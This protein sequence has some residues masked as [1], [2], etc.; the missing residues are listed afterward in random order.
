MKRK[1]NLFHIL[2]LSGVLILFNTGCEKQL[3]ERPTDFVGPANFYNT[4]AQIESAFTA[5]MD[6]LF[7]GWTFYDWYRYPQ[8]FD[9]DDQSSANGDD[10]LVIGDGLGNDC[11]TKHYQSIAFLNPAIKAIN[12]GK[13]T[14][15]DQ[16][17]QDKLM[18]Q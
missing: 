6:N 11:W 14:G 18:A 9:I 8:I 3:Q 13:L 2:A 17:A 7:G 5:S 15:V 1:I 16:T 10:N 4:P 12:D